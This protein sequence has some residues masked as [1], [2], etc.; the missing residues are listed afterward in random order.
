LDR[1]G[2]VEAATRRIHEHAARAHGFLAQLPPSASRDRL[3]EL[4][5]SA[6]D[7]DR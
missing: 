3:A 2:A 6:A 5:T 7:R 1:T 4:V